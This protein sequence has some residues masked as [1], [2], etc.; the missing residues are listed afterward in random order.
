M[1]PFDFINA[2]NSSGKPDLMSGTEND[3]LAE[4]AYVPYITNKSLSYFPDTLM[5]ANEMNRRSLL[6]NKLQ[7]H[8][9][10]NTI[11]PAK[12]FS[13]WIKK[14]EQADLEAIMEYYNY[15]HEKA[16]QVLPILSKDQLATIKTTLTGGIEDEYTR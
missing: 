8:Y 7:F 15:S 14:E 10:L 1:K 6:D 4:K 9:L 16:K 11:R 5:Y 12:R 3:E 2:I 13:K